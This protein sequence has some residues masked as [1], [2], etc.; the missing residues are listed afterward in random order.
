[1]VKEIGEG[2]KAMLTMG[3]MH[4][5]AHAKEFDQHLEVDERFHD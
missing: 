2:H 1:V 3:S 5:V 4:Y